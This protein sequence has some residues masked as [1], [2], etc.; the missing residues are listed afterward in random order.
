MN[1]C[2]RKI[3]RYEYE[4]LYPQVKQKAKDSLEMATNYVANAMLDEYQRRRMVNTCKRIWVPKTRIELANIIR[5]M[6]LALYLN[7]QRGNTVTQYSGSIPRSQTPQRIFLVTF[8]INL[9]LDIR[10]PKTRLRS[11]KLIVAESNVCIGTTP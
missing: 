5:P 9:R 11:P 10:Q 7:K 8:W 1:H 4:A 3:A 2:Q 6:S